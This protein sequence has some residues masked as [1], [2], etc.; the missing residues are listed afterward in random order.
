MVNCNNIISVTHVFRHEMW[1][2]ATTSSQSLMFS[3]MRSSQ[4][5]MFSVMRCGQLQHHLSHS[6]FLSWDHLSHSC[7]LSWD[8]LS[9]SC[10][11][12]W[13]VVNC[14]NIISV[15]RVFCHEMWSI[16]TKIP[17]LEYC[18]GIYLPVAHFTKSYIWHGRQMD[19]ETHTH[20]KLF[21]VLFHSCDKHI[22]FIL[23]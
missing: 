18:Y 21:I 22:Y 3:V 15:T 12:S 5:L 11:L 17:K 16:A 4:S 23:K 7:F 2:I 10:F 19:K 8:H 1:L 6:C 14:N 13:D 9:H 20:N